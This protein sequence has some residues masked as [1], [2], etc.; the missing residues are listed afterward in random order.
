MTG[1]KIPA[2]T[3][4]SNPCFTLLYNLAAANSLPSKPK[5]SFVCV[6]PPSKKSAKVCVPS[7]ETRA[8]ARPAAPIC[9]A[10]SPNF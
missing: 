4:P 1:G 10:A 5:V 6:G 2:K 7:V 3:L 8:S 9:R